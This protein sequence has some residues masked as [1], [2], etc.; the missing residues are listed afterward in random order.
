[1]I[2]PSSGVVFQALGDEAVLYDL[3]TETFFALNE[4][5]ARMWHLLVGGTEPGAVCAT[6]C[7]EYEVDPEQLNADLQAFIGQLLTRGLA[8][9]TAA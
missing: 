5:S 6:M 2:E 9:E 8:Q 4:T 1:M 7:E 3:D